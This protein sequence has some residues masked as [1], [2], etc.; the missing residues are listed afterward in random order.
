MGMGGASQAEWVEG[1]LVPRSPDT[2][3]GGWIR[4]VEFALQEVQVRAAAG[5]SKTG[6]GASWAQDSQAEPKNM[7]HAKHFS[8]AKFSPIIHVPY[9]PSMS[10]RRI[11]RRPYSK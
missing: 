6:A 8:R 1:E 9:T 11:F 4:D 3:N 5:G 2:L 10:S 7:V